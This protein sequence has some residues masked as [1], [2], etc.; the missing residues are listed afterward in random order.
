MTAKPAVLFLS[1]GG[2]EG[3]DEIMPFLERVTRG[4]GIPRARLEGVAEHYRRIGGRSPINAITRRQAD[5]L[6]AALKAAGDERPVYVGQRHAAPFVADALRRMRGDGV[7]SAVAFCTAAFRCEASLERYAQA[8][9]AARAEVGDGAP[10][11]GFVGPWFD[12]PFFMDAVAA[13]VREKGLPADAPWVFTAHSIPC[14]MAKK[15]LYVEELR[16]AAGLVAGKL[17][18]NEWTLAFTSRSGGPRDAWLEPDVREVIAAKASAGAREL[19]LIPIGFVADHVEVL[20]D[21][22]VEAAAAAAEAGVRLVRAET[23]G[24]HPLFVRMIAEVVRAGTPAD[25]ALAVDSSATRFRDGRVA[26]AAGEDAPV[27]YCRPGDPAPPCR[28]R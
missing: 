15:S 18:K 12:H 21:L 22:D 7:K 9:A 11:V 8:V 20:Y 19:A 16:A 4:R 25:A 5:A 24:D 23:V 10:E 28:R 14:A 27:C 3:P 26:K 13:R 17:G 6:R 1:F 2:P